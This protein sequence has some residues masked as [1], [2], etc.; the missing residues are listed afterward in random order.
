MGAANVQL[1]DLPDLLLVENALKVHRATVWTSASLHSSL[2]I[3][4]QP[5]SE[6][7]VTEMLTTASSE[8][9]IPQDLGTDAT[10]VLGRNSV[11]KLVVVSSVRHRGR[12]SLENN[13]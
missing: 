4:V 8:A 9:S 1:F 7:E 2:F 10:D 5:L 6:T 12:C 11:H 3:L 13:D